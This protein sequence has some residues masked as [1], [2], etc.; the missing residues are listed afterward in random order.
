MLPGLDGSVK[1]IKTYED[2][3]HLEKLVQYELAEYCVTLPNDRLSHEIFSCDVAIVF[4]TIDRVIAEDLLGV[5]ST[6]SSSGSA[7]SSGS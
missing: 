6:S 4:A 5:P 2:K 7:S 1:L 3:G